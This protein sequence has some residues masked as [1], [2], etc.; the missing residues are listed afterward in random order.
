CGASA[1]VFGLVPALRAS[2]PDLATV[3]RASGRGTTTGGSTLL[4][5]SVVIAEVAL[6]FVLLVGCGLMVRSAIALANTNPGFDPNGVLTLRVGNL[7]ARTPDER[8]GK[9]A[10][11]REKLGAV[12][13]V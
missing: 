6:S 3:L 9:L 7:R 11:I 10:A 5:K 13:G 1:V 2:R 12:P 4:R 8:A